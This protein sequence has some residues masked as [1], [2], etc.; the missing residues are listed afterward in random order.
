[1][2]ASAVLARSFLVDYFDGDRDFVNIVFT[3]DGT[4][5]RMTQGIGPSMRH[6][7]FDFSNA[8]G[9]HDISAYLSSLVD[10]VRAIARKWN[11]R[12]WWDT[13][14]EAPRKAAGKWRKFNRRAA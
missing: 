8:A 4:T 7:S 3:V 5:L 14:R 1:M 13:P 9:V 2:R 12:P 6:A 11:P 10:D